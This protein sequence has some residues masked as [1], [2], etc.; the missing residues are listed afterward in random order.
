MCYRSIQDTNGCSTFRL[1]LLYIISV[2]KE[3]EQKRLKAKRKA[4]SIINGMQNHLSSWKVRTDKCLIKSVLLEMHCDFLGLPV[5]YKKNL[6]KI[7]QPQ[8]VVEASEGI[9]H[10]IDKSK[11]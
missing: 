6:S 1:A 5:L 8:K 2:V 11:L 10:I 7:F 3:N 9:Y 4:V